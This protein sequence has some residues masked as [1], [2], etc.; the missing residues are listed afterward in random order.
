MTAKLLIQQRLDLLGLK[1]DSTGFSES[2]HLR[3][4]FDFWKVPGIMNTLCLLQ[5]KNFMLTLQ[6]NR[7]IHHSMNIPKIEFIAYKISKTQKLFII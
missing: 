3:N 5:S 1:I 6:E 7:S 2:I 4:E